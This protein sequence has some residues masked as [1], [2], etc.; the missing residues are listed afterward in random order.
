VRAAQT[1]GVVIPTHNPDVYLQEAIDSVRRQTFTSFH[2]YVVDDGSRTPP[3]LTDAADLTYVERSNTGVS[4]TRNFAASLGHEEL[5]AF[6]DQDDV[7]HPDKLA[8]QL[9][10]LADRPD[11]A[12]CFTWAHSI[13]ETGRTI[14][15]AYGAYDHDIS[16]GRALGGG[17]ILSSLLLRRPAFAEAGGFDPSLLIIQDWDLLIRVSLVGDV[18]VCRDRLTSYRVHD[19]N[20]SRDYRRLAAE[21]KSLLIQSQPMVTRRERADLYAARRDFARLAGSKANSDARRLVQEGRFLEAIGPA[22]WSVGQSC[23]AAFSA[24]RVRWARPR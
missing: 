3:R 16:G 14:G 21:S 8:Q 2:I 24:A 20:T 7:W 9:E 18:L 23:S 10:L 12:G 4:R 1:V 22:A 15:D 19:A 13:D 6:L 5:V 17:V 11:A